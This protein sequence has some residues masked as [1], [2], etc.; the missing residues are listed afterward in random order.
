MTTLR[1]NNAL[2]SSLSQK[3]AQLKHVTLDIYDNARSQETLDNTVSFFSPFNHPTSPHTPP[4]TKL[5]TN[6]SS[7]NRMKSF[8]I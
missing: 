6:I 3:T 2:L 8:Q 4:Q 5:A 7:N 1:Q